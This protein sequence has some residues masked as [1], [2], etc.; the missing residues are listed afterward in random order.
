MVLAITPK[1]PGGEVARTRRV[2]RDLPPSPDF[3]EYPGD[4]GH[5]DYA[6]YNGP[7]LATKLLLGLP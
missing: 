6:L 5:R 7:H 4:S 1:F 2:V 3:P